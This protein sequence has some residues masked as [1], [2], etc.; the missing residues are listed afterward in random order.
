MSNLLANRQTEEQG[1]S[2]RPQW[3]LLDIIA[4]VVLGLAVGYALAAAFA[5]VARALGLTFTRIQLIAIAGTLLYLG[6]AL[7]VWFFVVRRRGVTWRDI[8]FA[9]PHPSVIVWTPVALILLFMADAI[10]ANLI[11]LVSGSYQ[12]PQVND[13]APNG[14]IS[15]N[16]FVWL[17][18]IVAVVAPPVEE[19]VFRGLLYRYLRARMGVWIAVFASAAIFALA[20]AIPILLPVLFVTGIALAIMAERFKSIYASMLLHAL[21]NAAFVYALYAASSMPR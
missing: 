6:V 13:I 14:R 3:R 17:L 16:S 19:M 15:F 21:N 18:L 8:G 12:N 9:P 20:H 11:A 1:R 2:T 10:L 5:F 4:S 7:A